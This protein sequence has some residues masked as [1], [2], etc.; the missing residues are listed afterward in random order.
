M[1]MSPMNFNASVGNVDLSYGGHHHGKKDKKHHGDNQEQSTQ[2]T[3]SVQG[4]YRSRGNERPQQEAPVNTKSVE[5]A[6]P[7]ITT[8]PQE[9]KSEAAPPDA[10]KTGGTSSSGT[11]TIN[12][13]STNDMHGYFKSMA[14]VSGL[15]HDLKHQH[16]DALVVDVGDVAYNPPY[17]DRNHFDPMVDIMNQIGYN[18]VALGNHEFQWS[19]GELHDEYV[20]KIKA[21]VVCANVKDPDSGSYLPDVKPYVI[22][23]VNGIKVGI[24]G[25]VVPDMATSAHPNVGGDVKKQDIEATV[26]SL[27]PEMKKNGAEVIVCLSHHG[28]HNGADTQ[29]AKNVDGIDVIFTAH[30]HQLTEEAIEVGQFPH[31]TYVFQ[32]QS[33]AKYVGFAQLEIDNKTHKMID[34]H[35]KAMPT[36]ASTV[37]AD[38]VVDDIIRNYQEHSGSRSGGHVENPNYNKPNNH[39]GKH[40]NRGH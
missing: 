8:E 9:L 29:M 14:D 10:P 5:M 26:K 18:V 3:V 19:K 7:G 34:A 30:D 4:D 13:I 28:I 24:I 2:D 22:K 23:D 17:S 21:D 31:K 35:I 38:P 37:K 20:S 36:Q 12:I 16:P 6:A 40:G 39:H 15:V 25:T 1:D 32:G 11:T 27:I 33:H